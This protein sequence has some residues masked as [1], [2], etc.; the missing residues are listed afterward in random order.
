MLWNCDD[1]FVC[2][3]LVPMVLN[4]LLPLAILLVW[5]VK[6]MVTEKIPGRGDETGTKRRMPIP[7]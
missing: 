7:S 3:L 4:I 6:C 5:L 2:M 1:L